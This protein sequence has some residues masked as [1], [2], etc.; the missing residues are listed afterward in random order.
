MNASDEQLNEN[1]LISRL[2]KIVNALSEDRQLILLKQLLK[3]NITNHLFK[4]I[5]DMSDYQQHIL[6][7]E[8]EKLPADEM[9]VRTVSLDENG[10]LMRGHTRK[11]C[12]TS[13][14]FSFQNSSFKGHILDISLVGVFIETGELL[15][16]GENIKVTFSLPNHPKPLTLTCIVAWIGQNGIGVKFKKLTKNHEKII[17]SFVE[18]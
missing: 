9:P 10:V 8:L 14:D 13:V 2:F 18:N 1:S 12:L 5:I 7:E 16:V 3:N 6:L 15:P 17:K 11:A 4:L